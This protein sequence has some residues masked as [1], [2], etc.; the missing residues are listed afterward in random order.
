[1]ATSLLAFLVPSILFLASVPPSHPHL[2]LDHYKKTCPRFN[3]I[4]LQVISEKQIHY[5]STA[6]GTLRLFF[7]DCIV[8]GCD[9]SILISSTAFSKAERDHELNAG[10]P[11]DAFEVITR[12]KSALEIE[13]PGVVSCSDIIAVATRNLVTIVGGPFY[14]VRL[15]RKDGLTSNISRV[16]GNLPNPKM[17]MSEII[18]FF[19]SRGFTVEDMVALLGSHTIGFSHCK[20]FSDRLFN[21]SKS[22]ETDPAYHPEYAAGLKKLCANYTKNPDMSAY[23]DVMT[24]GKFDNMYYQNLK[25]GLGLLATDSALVRD[26]RT[27]PF[28]DLYAANETAFFQAYG[29]AMEKL[30]EYKVK[31]G[32][33]GEIRRSCDD[34]NIIKT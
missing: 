19:T 18:S 14:Q 22:S 11:G 10:L 23:N 29:R 17:P 1:M 16:D 8:E 2:S 25:K 4:M 20:E 32:K 9:G 13:C 6:A 31:T 33:E 12:A 7:H 27:G 30:G 26:K 24:P 15:G 3:E 5:P 21:F 28:V 34:F